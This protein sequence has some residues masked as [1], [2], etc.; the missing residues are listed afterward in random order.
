M[1]KI[2]AVKQVWIDP[3]FEVE[4][5]KKKKTKQNKT[6]KQTIGHY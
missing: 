3:H 6:N 1:S 2:I 5:S 4:N